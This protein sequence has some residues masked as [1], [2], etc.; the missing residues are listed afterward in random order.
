[1]HCA[2]G[3]RAGALLALHAFYIEG[4]TKEDALAR[5]E[6]AGLTNLRD[7]VEARLR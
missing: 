2:S 7:A 1:L 4:T 5:G 6:A 3:N